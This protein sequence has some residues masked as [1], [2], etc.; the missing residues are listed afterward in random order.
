VEWQQVL[1]S[2]AGSGPLAGALAFALWK[3]WARCSELEAQLKASQ[4]ARI[5]DLKSILTHDT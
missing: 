2:L 4:D 3:M 5:E 1:E